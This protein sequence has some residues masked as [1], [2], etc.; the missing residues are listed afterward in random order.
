MSGHI[1]LPYQPFFGVW[2]NYETPWP[3]PVTHCGIGD[4][5]PALTILLHLSHNEVFSFY[6]Y[7]RVLRPPNFLSYQ[8]IRPFVR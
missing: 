3:T 8:D 1:T 6:Q 2:L 4:M 5:D 7:I